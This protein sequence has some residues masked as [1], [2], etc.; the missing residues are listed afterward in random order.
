MATR[1]KKEESVKAEPVTEVSELINDII[2]D[3][4]E[5]KEESPEVKPE[6]KEVKPE[7]PNL[8]K[9]L[10]ELIEKNE[11]TQRQILDKAHEAFPSLLKSTISTILSDSKNKKYSKW[12]FVVKVDEKGI[13][14]FSDEKV[15]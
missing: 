14:K 3:Q 2:T 4:P 1:T 5:V 7:K 9:F 13:Y 8:R 11:F 6:K 10:K 15:K 12:E